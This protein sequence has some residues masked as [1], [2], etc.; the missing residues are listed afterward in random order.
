[1][2]K[3][4]FSAIS[5]ALAPFFA[6]LL[7]TFGFMFVGF[8]AFEAVVRPALTKLQQHALTQLNAI[9]PELRQFVFLTGINDVISIV[10]G[11]F[12]AALAIK[13]AK[14]VASA[15]ASKYKEPWNGF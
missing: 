11:A 1:M 7:S 4:I 6:R 15:K 8:A 10:F 12:F 2:F 14:A 5:S 3:T 9:P 13:G